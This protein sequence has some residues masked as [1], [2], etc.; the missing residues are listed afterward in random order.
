MNK[1]VEFFIVSF[2]VLKFLVTAILRNLQLNIRT[3]WNIPMYLKYNLLDID[4]NSNIESLC[5]KAF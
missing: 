4:I 1:V 2:L 5:V 3:F